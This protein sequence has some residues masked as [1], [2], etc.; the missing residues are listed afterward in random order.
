MFKFAV[1]ILA[2]AGCAMAKPGILAPVAPLAYTAPAALVA[3]PAPVVT[4]TSSQVFARNYN[5]IAT[6][7]VIAPAP[8]IA[9][10]AVPAPIAA[11][12]AAPLAAAPLAVAGSPILAKY[13]SPAALAYSAPLSYGVSTPLLF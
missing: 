8:V 10:Y 3:A 7:P 4:A 6:A 5:G 9:K 11:P 13:A 12:L 2:V 1:L